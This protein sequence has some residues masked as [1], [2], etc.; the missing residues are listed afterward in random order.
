VAACKSVALSASCLRVLY[1]LYREK[2]PMAN[3][4]AA[5]QKH[6]TSILVLILS[7]IDLIA[8]PGLETDI[9]EGC[10]CLALLAM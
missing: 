3:R 2:Q 7:L 10:D 5:T 1:S 4:G 6:S 8:L 9:L